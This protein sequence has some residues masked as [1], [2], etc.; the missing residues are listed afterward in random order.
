MYCPRC[1]NSMKEKFQKESKK[2]IK[3]VRECSCGYNDLEYISPKL[4]K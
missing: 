3:V 1:H 2:Y 4:N